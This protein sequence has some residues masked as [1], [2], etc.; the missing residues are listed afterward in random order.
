MDERTLS[1]MCDPETRDSLELDTGALL[2]PKSGRRHPI[3]NGI[4]IYFEALSSSSSQQSSRYT[5]SKPSIRR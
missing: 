4:P 3:R 2:N 1:L 5:L